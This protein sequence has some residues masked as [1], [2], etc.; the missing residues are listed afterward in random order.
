MHILID[1]NVILRFLKND[2]K[3]QSPRAKKLFKK[4]SENK[5]VLYI[6]PVTIAEVLYVLNSVY[7]VKRKIAGELLI[8]LLELEN[9]E[10]IGCKKST[11]TSAIKEYFIVK[12]D[13]E[14]CFLK[15]LSIEHKYKIA[16]FDK[17]FKKIGASLYKI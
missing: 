2:H 7:R 9:I 3:T 10:I 15:Y 14:D 4:V 8:D 6:N 17:D 11:L 13:F 12:V 16:T 1:A 5:V